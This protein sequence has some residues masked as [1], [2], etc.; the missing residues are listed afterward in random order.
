MSLL[1][2]LRSAVWLS[3]LSLGGIAPAQPTTETN[4]PALERFL[5]IVETSAPM[6]KRAENTQ[7]LVANIIAAGLNGQMGSRASLGLW[8]FNDQLLTGKLPAQTW[9]PETRQLLGLTFARVLQNQPYE[10]SPQLSVIWEAVT[11][12]V[13]KSDHLTLL[14]LTSG[15]NP[16][17]GTPYD[18]TISATFASNLEQQRQANMPFLTILRAVKGQFVAFSVSTPPWPLE[19]PEYPEEFKMP[20]VVNPP[21]LRLAPTSAP[22][23]IIKQSDLAPPPED[24]SYYLP[25]APDAV[26]NLGLAATGLIYLEISNSIAA[27]PTGTNAIV[28]AITPPSADIIRTNFLRDQ[29]TE[30]PRPLVQRPVFQIGALVVFLLV[31]MILRRRLHRKSRAAVLARSAERERE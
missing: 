8:T 28:T 19:I 22:P 7:R 16:I 9:T 18:P 21:P 27:S 11:N 3:L 31:M 10:K 29:E 25:I 23:L 14:L 2:I 20:A 15:Q 30:T 13:A 6:Q 5:F 17:H 12:I 24:F 4:A 1:K 26:T